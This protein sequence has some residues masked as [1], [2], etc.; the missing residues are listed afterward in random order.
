MERKFQVTFQNQFHTV[1]QY[2]NGKFF[3]V[4]GF[5]IDEGK[6]MEFGEWKVSGQ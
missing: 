1:Y 4:F 3:Q 5:R 2:R 6:K